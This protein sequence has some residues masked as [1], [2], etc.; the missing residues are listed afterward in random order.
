MKEKF[1]NRKFTRTLYGK[2]KEDWWISDFTL[3]ELKELYVN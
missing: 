1:E 2:D 3:E